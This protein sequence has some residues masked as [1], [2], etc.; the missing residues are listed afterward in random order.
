MV[1]DE[2]RDKLRASRGF[3]VADGAIYIDHRRAI[4]IRITV[5]FLVRPVTLPGYEIGNAVAV[6]VRYRGTMDLTENN[7]PGILRTVVACDF[8]LSPCSVLL[9]F[10]PT[11]PPFMSRKAGDDVRQT[12]AVDVVD[13]HLRAAGPKVRRV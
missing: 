2:F 13:T 12:I 9:L 7:S 1:V 3:G 6:H 11:Q 5:S 8:V 10:I 4:Q